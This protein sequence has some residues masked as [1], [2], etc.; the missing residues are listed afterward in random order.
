MCCRAGGTVINCLPV[1]EPYLRITAPT[2]D[3]YYFIKDLKSFYIKK[4]TWFYNPRKKKY[5]KL[6]CKVSNKTI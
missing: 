5:K 6:I 2:S 3:L 4:E 1:P